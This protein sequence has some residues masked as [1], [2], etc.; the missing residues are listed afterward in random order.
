MIEAVR[1]ASNAEDLSLSWVSFAFAAAVLL[2]CIF[3]RSWR[4]SF[5]LLPYGWKT[6]TGIALIIMGLSIWSV[7][8]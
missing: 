4:N 5:K 1:Q 2:G 3:S 7:V 6:P 8:H